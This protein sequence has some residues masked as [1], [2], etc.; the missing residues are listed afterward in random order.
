M[1]IQWK[2]KYS[3]G[4]QEIDDQHKYFIGLL[5]ELYNAI[6][7][8]QGREELSALFQKVADYAE[9]HFAAEEKYFDEFNYDGAA[10]HKLEHEKMRAEIKKIKS[11]AGGNEI[12]FY[13]NIVYF[14]KD[15]LDDHLEKMDQKYKECFMSH[16]LR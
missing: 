13:G 12:D 3:V 5:N 15:W 7:S 10:E 9:K 1:E 14:L 2:E 4:I 11:Q 6:V 16:G 8:N